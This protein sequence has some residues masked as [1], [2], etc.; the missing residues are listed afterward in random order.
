MYPTFE[1]AQTDIKEK[2]E[3]GVSFNLDW[4][5]LAAEAARK[6]RAT[7]SP[8]TIK[9]RVPV[10][11][12]IQDSLAV[13]TCPTDIHTPADL[14]PADQSF[15]G[16]GLT[17]TAAQHF[18]HNDDVS[19]Y[20]IDFINGLPFIYARTYGV[21]QSMTFLNVSDATIAGD[22]AL[23]T[24]L[25]NFLYGANA[26]IGTFTDSD[27]QITWTLDTAQDLT[28]Y[29]RGVAVIPFVALADVTKVAEIKLTLQSS[30]GNV[31]TV[32]TTEDVM[33][34][35]FTPGWNFA[36]L[37]LANKA[38]TGSP[39]ITN[40]TAGKLDIVMATGESQEVIIDN[41]TLHQ[42]EAAY[43]EYYSNNNF[44]DTS[45]TYIAKP[46][47]DQDE[48]LFREEAYDVWQYEVC[49]LIVQNATYDAVDSKESTRLEQNLARAYGAYNAKYPSQ[50]K[51]VTYNIASDL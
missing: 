2:F 47:N 6:T 42:T 37:D 13:L 24:T 33:G 19:L 39:D 40:I 51:P 36:R 30:T 23:A 12:G 34:N 48:I 44:R 31:F 5:T 11:G 43:F 21:G 50:Q 27:T 7:I 28:N 16:R 8:S 15:G 1:Q 49:M 9:R 10:Y 3:G 29:N 22:V 46:E 32:T 20:T 41:I 35:T 38:S 18:F 14:Y 17:H 4:S 26:K 25:R 45:G